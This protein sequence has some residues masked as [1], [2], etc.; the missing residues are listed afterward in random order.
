MLCLTVCRS[1][2]WQ[3]ALCHFIY[4]MI[5]DWLIVALHRNAQQKMQF[6]V[7]HAAWSV[8]WSQTWVVKKRLNWEMPFR[9]GIKW[10]KKPCFGWGPR[11][12]HGKRHFWGNTLACPDLSADVLNLIRKVAAFGYQYCS[13]LFNVISDSFLDT[14]QRD[15]GTWTPCWGLHCCNKHD[16]HHHVPE[17]QLHVAWSHNGWNIGQ[18]YFFIKLKF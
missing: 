1:I 5:I 9:S 4:L 14:V 17:Y 10:T 15:L 12:H 8:C 16:S 7:K 2:V 18:L 13:N 6:I 3:N 11:S